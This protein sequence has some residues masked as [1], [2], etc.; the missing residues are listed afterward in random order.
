MK[1]T[2]KTC[3]AAMVL[4]LAICCKKENSNITSLPANDNS[5][6]AA[7]STDIDG[8]ARDTIRIGT[9]VWRSINLNLSRYR[10]GDKIPQVTDPAEWAALTTGA[11]CYYN[12][13]P[14]TG[15]IY[16][17]L[18]NWYAVNDPRGLA[19]AGWHVPSDA[20]WATLTTFL[21]GEAVAGGKMKE[22]GKKHWIAPNKDATNSSGFTGIPGGVRYNFE[23]S[24]IGSYCYWWSSTEHSTDYSWD[25]FLSYTTGFLFQTFNTKRNGFSVR[26][27]RD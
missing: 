23:F 3:L 10:N 5:S 26:C 15:A 21:G 11:W 9:Q 12:N 17:K 20:E 25:C 2:I 14:A 18:Y 22:T 8:A 1:T 4:L 13:D 6:T 24:G 27:L 19:P 16:G 7:L